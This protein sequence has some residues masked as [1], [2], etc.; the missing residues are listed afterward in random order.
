M[1]GIGGVG[2]R[3]MTA[4]RVEH[5]TPEWEREDS[6]RIRATT[7]TTDS[8]SPT[9]SAVIMRL[10]SV[11]LP[12]RSV[13]SHRS[14]ASTS[15]APTQTVKISAPMSRRALT[16]CECNTHK[17]AQPERVLNRLDRRRHVGV[18]VGDR[19]FCRVPTAAAGSTIWRKTYADAET[20][21][22]MPCD[23]LC[24]S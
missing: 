1:V 21:R 12:S 13:S 22:A 24:P 9:Q 15:G 17:T 8:A 20:Y 6:K 10:A 2:I 4:A 18:A 7:P 23:V 3:Q 11:S 16:I 14:N 5:A 19:S